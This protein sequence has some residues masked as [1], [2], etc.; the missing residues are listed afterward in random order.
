MRKIAL[1]SIVM[2]A[3]ATAAQAGSLMWGASSPGWAVAGP[4]IFKLDTSSGQVV[5][6]STWTYSD[7]NW[8]MGIADS[9]DYLYATANDLTDAGN[10]KLRKID[11]TDGTVLSTTDVAGLLGT[12]YSHINALEYV[13]GT[14]YGVENSTWDDTYRGS[15][16]VMPLDTSGEV[17]SAS[18]G[19]TVGPNPDGALEHNDGTFYASDWKSGGD[20]GESWIATL[21]AADIADST[22]TFAK[23]PY[24][25]PASGLI[26]G[27]QFDENGGFIGVSWQNTGLYNIDPATGET[28]TLYQAIT[29]VTNGHTMSGLD[30]VVP[31]PLTMLAV[32]SAVAGLGG[33]IRRRRRG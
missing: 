15:V 18:V 5:S 22:K 16:I 1:M 14:L 21:D 23:S 31:E 12:D 19:A 3:M 8:I 28:T 26:D 29:G 6:G 17:L 11:R 4:E 30:A 20:P 2:L 25:N 7:W 9:G 32:G 24:T 27:W 13:D 33:Y 10:V